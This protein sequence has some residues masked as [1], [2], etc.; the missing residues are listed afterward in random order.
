MDSERSSAKKAIKEPEA[1]DP[2]FSQALNDASHFRISLIQEQNRHRENMAKGERGLLGALFGGENLAPTMIAF[3]I[4]VF[5]LLGWG[6][7]LLAASH[8]EAESV[9][10]GDQAGRALALATTA[11]GFIFGRGLK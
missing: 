3:V 8:Y 7:C 6:V 4:S 9:F 2:E 10:W 5:G 1:T 11:I